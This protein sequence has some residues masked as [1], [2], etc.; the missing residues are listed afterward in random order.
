MKQPCVYIITNKANGT[1]YIGVTSDLP[2]RI[3]QHK[4]KQIEGFSKTYGL[5]RL[6][7]YQTASSMNSAIEEEKR[8]KAGSRESKINLI[9][10]MNPQWRDLYADII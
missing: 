7:W 3:F 9:R 8:L 6:V 2:R 5:D 10:K 1:L 4:Q